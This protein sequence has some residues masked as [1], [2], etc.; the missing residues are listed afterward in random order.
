M[1]WKDPLP[2]APHLPSSMHSLNFSARTFQQQAAVLFSPLQQNFVTK[3]RPGAHTQHREE[4]RPFVTIFLSTSNKS[5]GRCYGCLTTHDVLT[6]RANGGRISKGNVRAWVR[7]SPVNQTRGGT[8]KPAISVDIF[9]DYR[10]K[11]NEVPTSHLYPWG[12]ESV[13]GAL[14]FADV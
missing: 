2:E 13:Y 10:R 3:W 14:G 6:T 8:R 4:G 9:C 5:D 7:S 11:M 1:L 12:D